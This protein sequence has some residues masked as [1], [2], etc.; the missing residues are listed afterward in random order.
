MQVN[1]QRTPGEPL[2]KQAHVRLCTHTHAHQHNNTNNSK[3]SNFRI[4][5]Y[6]CIFRST[7][8]AKTLLSTLCA[9][10]SPLVMSSWAM[11]IL[12]LCPSLLDDTQPASR[13]LQPNKCPFFCRTDQRLPCLYLFLIGL[14]SKPV[15]KREHP[16]PIRSKMLFLP[17]QTNGRSNK[18]V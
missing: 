7:S 2:R 18:S 6:Y 9:P 4:K 10:S 12:L 13:L 14:H 8:Y 3:S 11:L 17:F 1:M 16:H 15:L 5:C